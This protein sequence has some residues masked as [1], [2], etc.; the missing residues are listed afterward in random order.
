MH[1]TVELLS[2]ELTRIRTSRPNPAI[3]DGVKVEYYGAPTPLKSLAAISVPDPKQIVVQPYDRN[4]LADVERAITKANLGLNPIVEGNLVRL[5]IPLLT[6]ERRKELV[7][8]CHKLTED[9][10]IAIRNVRRD[11]NDEI[12]KLEKEKRISEDDS[13]VGTKRVQELT[14][15]QIKAVDELFG[16]KQKEILEK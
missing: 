11:A 15:A 6:E 8:L 14:D 1:K 12:K 4:A 16:K 9:A 3:L 13:K 5:P 7:K 2:S 10:H